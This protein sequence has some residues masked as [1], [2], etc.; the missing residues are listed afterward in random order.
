MINPER[1]NVEHVNKIAEIAS[2]VPFSNLIERI[3][4]IDNK[5]ITP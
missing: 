2:N 4:N 1:A 3:N 5:T